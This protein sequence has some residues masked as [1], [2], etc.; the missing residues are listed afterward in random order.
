MIDQ[1]TIDQLE[2]R[3]AELN[4]ELSDPAVY[5]SAASAKVV[6]E[7]R[8]VQNKLELFH[9]VV[10]TETELRE[11]KNLL[12][13][14]EMSELARAEIPELEGKLD[15]LK[16]K[17][18]IA[19]V[20]KDPNDSKDAIMEIRAGAGGD[21]SSLFAGEL[22]RMYA[23]FC[24]AHGLNMQIMTDS[25]GT[26][27]G[28]KELIAEVS[29]AD[30]YGTLKYESGVHRVQRIPATESAGRIHTSTV[31]VAVLPEAEEHDIEIDPAELR[32]DVY[33]SSGNGGQ[34]VN[35]TDSAVRVTHLPTNTV[36]T[37][38]DEKSQLKNKLKAMSILRSR[39]LAVKQEQELKELG[40]ARLSQIGTGDR[41][42]KIRTY[43]FPQDRITDHRI[44]F[45]RHNLPGF[46]D[47]EIDDVLTALR[48]AD[49]TKALEG[50]LGTEA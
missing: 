5:A 49:I 20:P 32:I 3:L 24:E 6:A 14:P 12:N 29:G 22:S 4:A 44:G 47:G 50:E 13:D 25:P 39:L 21:E 10:Q 7:Q 35:T 45:T 31:T 17:V 34:S 36:V 16:S 42:E 37:C 2:K 41:S 28:Y 40:E 15:E 26:S 23:R 30:A 27:G 46:L 1:S 11:A 48:E 19:L 18:R 38:Q 33:R 43:N 9:E 8:D